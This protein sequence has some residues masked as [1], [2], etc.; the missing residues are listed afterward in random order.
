MNSLPQ[1]TQNTVEISSLK[2]D[3][4]Q[5]MTNHLPHL[6][7]AIEKIDGKLDRLQWFFFVTA[8]GMIVNV[9]LQLIKIA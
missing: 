9:M 2:A 7:T 4:T 3:M 6:Q 5:I 1:E 8:V